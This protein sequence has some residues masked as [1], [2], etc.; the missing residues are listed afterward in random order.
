MPDVPGVLVLSFDDGSVGHYNVARPILAE[1]GVKAS[2]A[3]CRMYATYPSGFM[4]VDMMKALQADGHEICNHTARHNNDDGHGNCSTWA[5]AEWQIGEQKQ[6]MLD[7]G[8]DWPHS[9]VK[10]GVGGYD[11]GIAQAT[12]KRFG[13]R[14][15]REN[16]G[17]IQFHGTSAFAIPSSE[18]FTNV[19]T[20]TID[21]RL[22]LLRQGFASYGVHFHDAGT[23]EANL[24][25]LLTKCRE[26]GIEVMRIIDWQ[27][28]QCLPRGKNL[29]PRTDLATFGFGSGSFAWSSSLGGGTASVTPEGGI[30]LSRPTSM[31]STVT[32]IR[33]HPL[34]PKV[35]V[36]CRIIT[37]NV[38]STNSTHGACVY[39]YA[40]Y[41]GWRPIPASNIT[42]TQDVQVD[43]VI[44]V[45]SDAW[46]YV[47][48]IER[49][50][51]C[52][53]YSNTGGTAEFRDI[54]VTPV[55]SREAR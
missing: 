1:Y 30:L 7:N 36:R 17:G 16:A 12:L 14:N 35:R 25:Y 13:Y 47:D 51:R 39:L 38:S 24:R 3:V 28:R 43:Q 50:F 2:F 32:N 18:D 27:N 26:Y 8:F 19:T 5:G 23:G 6:W 10:P 53:L 31:G 15:M 45:P 29:V 40:P 42:G 21:D 55:V 20:A 49:Y 52:Y 34:T 48:G 9:F 46:S 22:S 11:S 37:N 54:S 44:D 4:T 41:W 33:I